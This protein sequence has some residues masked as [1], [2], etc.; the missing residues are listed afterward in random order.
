[1]PVLQGAAG[2][3]VSRPPI[4]PCRR[5]DVQFNTRPSDPDRRRDRA[6]PRRPFTDAERGDEHRSEIGRAHVLNSSHVKISYAV[7]CLKKKKDRLPSLGCEK[8]A[9]TIFG[10][11]VFR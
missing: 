8:S 9:W 1:M 10:R 2:D 7:F 5:A 3:L 4:T 11:S 6:R